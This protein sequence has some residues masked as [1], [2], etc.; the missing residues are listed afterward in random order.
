MRNTRWNFFHHISPNFLRK[1][2]AKPRPGASSENDRIFLNFA[3]SDIGHVTVETFLYKRL[4]R[5]IVS[6]GPKVFFS[7]DRYKV[8]EYE[9]RR[10]FL[11][12]SVNRSGDLSEQLS[13]GVM[14]ADL[15]AKADTDYVRVDQGRLHCNNNIKRTNQIIIKKKTKTKWSNKSLILKS[16]QKWNKLPSSI[17]TFNS[18][19]CFKMF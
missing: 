9:D 3:F 7:S 8:E 2:T 17:R 1:F 10:N 4:S 14:S 15:S 13:V 19:T 11:T 5:D 6:S 12:V 18:K 16:V